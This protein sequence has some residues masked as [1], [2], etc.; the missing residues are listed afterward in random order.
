MSEAN[1]TRRLSIGQCATLATLLEASAPKPGNVH[2]GAD[3]ADLT[4]YD[5]VASAV[6]IGPVM[7]AAAAGARLGPTVLAAVQATRAAV[8]TNANL[9]T[10]LLIAPVAKV[11]RGEPWRE[12]VAA[13][14]ATLDRAD[15][16]RVYEAI[17][18]AQPGGMGRVE[19]GD[20]HDAPPDD[21]VAAM[22]LAADRDLV[23]RQYV[24]NFAEVFENVVPALVSGLASG[25]GLVDAIIHAQ[26][27]LLSQLPDSLIARKCGPEVARQASEHAGSVLRAGAP[28][29]EEYHAA[30]ADLDFWLRADGHRRN[31]GTTADLLA[32]GLFVCLRDGRI[33]APYKF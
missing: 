19:Q 22:R 17:H 2:R 16:H 14:L 26:I 10:I 20:I 8:K 11:A 3:F 23:A 33:N 1:P 18:L 6:A 29:D 32:A 15:C 5:F 28:G 24:N 9:G 27:Q 25:Y 12:G 13:V 30:L 4:Y 21:L 31:P 7:E